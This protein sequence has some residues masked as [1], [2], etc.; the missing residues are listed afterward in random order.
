VLFKQ[1]DIDGSGYITRENFKEAMEKFGREID[2]DDIDI[3]LEL[4][5]MKGD[6]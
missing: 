4:H 2:D 1:F 5:D 6:G 3:I